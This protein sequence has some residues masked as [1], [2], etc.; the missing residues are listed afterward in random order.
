MFRR[1]MGI[2]GP[3]APRMVP[4][5]PPGW[6]ADDKSSLMHPTQSPMTPSAPNAQV[7]RGLPRHGA[8][9]PTAARSRT[10]TT[11]SPPSRRHWLRAHPHVG[12]PTRRRTPA[13]STGHRLHR[14]T[15]TPHR[16][17]PGR[18]S[19]Q[20]ATYSR[21]RGKRHPRPHLPADPQPLAGPTPESTSNRRR[22]AACSPL[23]AAETPPR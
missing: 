14:C 10:V 1:G 3:R 15:P 17:N 8:A 5:L 7:G 2:P 23:T 21:G 6:Y 18:S 4:S 20:R 13:G 11:T 16:P 19:L 9:A 12:V 22:H